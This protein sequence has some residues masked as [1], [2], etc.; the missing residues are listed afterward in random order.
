MSWLPCGYLRVISGLSCASRKNMCRLTSKPARKPRL[1]ENT[2]KSTIPYSSRINTRTSNTA[3][4]TS[5]YP[6]TS[7]SWTTEAA[8]IIRN[9]P[10]LVNCV[11]IN[12]SSKNMKVLG[13]PQVF[14]ESIL[15]NFFTWNIPFLWFYIKLLMHTHVLFWLIKGCQLFRNCVCDVTH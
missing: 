14:D 8:G 7:H 12:C 1:K 2:T 13:S 6:N 15:L 4:T 11:H 9:S 3:S 5:L 10:Y